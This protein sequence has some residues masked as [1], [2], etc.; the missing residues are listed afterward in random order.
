MIKIRDDLHYRWRDHSSEYELGMLTGT[1]R[2]GRPQKGRI[3]LRD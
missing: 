1:G 2:L 3:R